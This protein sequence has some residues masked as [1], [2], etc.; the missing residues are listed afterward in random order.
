[1]FVARLELKI[2]LV[3]IVWIGASQQERNSHGP[4]GVC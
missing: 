4:T 3:R 2:D 1:L